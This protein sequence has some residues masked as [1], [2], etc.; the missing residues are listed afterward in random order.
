MSFHKSCFEQK[1][2]HWIFDKRQ[3]DELRNLIRELYEFKGTKQR[4]VS[5]TGNVGKQVYFNRIMD[6]ITNQKAVIEDNGTVSY[7]FEEDERIT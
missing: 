5:R 4:G 3:T 6:Y 7:F 2:K 1:E